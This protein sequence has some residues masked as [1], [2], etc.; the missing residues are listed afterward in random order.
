MSKCL[1]CD[2][3]IESYTGRRPKKFCSDTCRATYHQKP[4]PKTSVLRKTFED[5]MEKNK[6]LETQLSELLSKNKE[7]VAKSVH[8]LAEVGMAITHTDN[9]GKAKRIDPLSEEGVIIQR[10]AILEKELK[11]P[12][13]TAIIGVKNWIMTRQIELSKLKEKLNPTN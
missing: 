3:P 13:K 10:I 8:D 12:P 9:E 1:Q 4:R 5:V 11:N 7:E 6:A 2:A